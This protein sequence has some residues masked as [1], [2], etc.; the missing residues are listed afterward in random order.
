MIPNY[1][2]PIQ[3][4]KTI[5]PRDEHSQSESEE[6]SDDDTEKKEK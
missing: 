6:S 4:Q 5:F 1:V 2:S 3:E